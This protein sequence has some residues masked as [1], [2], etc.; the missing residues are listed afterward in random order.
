MIIGF[1]LIKGAQPVRSAPFYP[2]GIIENILL[3]YN[4]LKGQTPVTKYQPI[5]RAAQEEGFDRPT[6][7]SSPRVIVGLVI[8]GLVLLVSLGAAVVY[9]LQPGAPTESLRDMF[10]ILVALEFLVVGLALMLLLVQLARLINLLNNEVR[11]ILDS[12]SEA[13][14]TMRGTSRFL[15]DKLVAPVVKVS[16]GVAGFRRALDLLKFWVRK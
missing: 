7:R 1:Y 9:L 13:A 16:A 2:E 14:N 12:V 11:P 4:H 8:L 10:I 3:R 6:P 15:S 5:D